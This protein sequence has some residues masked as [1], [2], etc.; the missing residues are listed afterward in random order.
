MI[1][2]LQPATPGAHEKKQ[3]VDHH[4]Q[5]STVVMI[6]M[7]EVEWYRPCCSLPKRVIMDDMAMVIYTKFMSVRVLSKPSVVLFGV[8]QFTSVENQIMLSSS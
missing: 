6:L 5:T 3:G 8:G 7:E 4:V 2:N 1:G